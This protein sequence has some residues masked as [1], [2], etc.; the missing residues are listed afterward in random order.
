MSG[1][2]A[3]M[4]QQATNSPNGDLSV[5]RVVSRLHWPRIVIFF[6]IMLFAV[7]LSLAQPKPLLDHFGGSYVQLLS[8]IWIVTSL[9]VT[10]AV[11]VWI[12]LAYT[13]PRI[14]TDA[15]II[16]DKNRLTVVQ[17]LQRRCYLAS[18][19]ESVDRGAGGCDL[20]RCDLLD[21][22]SKIARCH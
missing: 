6:I 11:S 7:F 12:Y 21:Q 10:I 1:Q 19:E 17:S 13:I 4:P 2:D 20:R 3:E 8:R 9:A 15:V 18:L 22:Q 14:S 16:T 5:L